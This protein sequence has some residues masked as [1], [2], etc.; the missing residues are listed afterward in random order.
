MLAVQA[1]ADN[2]QFGLDADVRSGL[3]S[4][5]LRLVAD[6]ELADDLTQEALAKAHEKADQFRGEGTRAAWL[7]G[8]ALNI[9]RDHFRKENRRVRVTSNPDL[10]NSIPDQG[11]IEAEYLENEMAVCIRRFVFALPRRQS[12]MIAMHDLAGLDH[13][14]AAKRLDISPANGRVLLHRGRKN[15]R[16]KLEKECKLDFDGDSAPCE[17][18]ARK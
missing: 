3:R 18:R 8:I 12:E 16:L 13:A 15:L 14:E 5:V 17:P 7:R 9:V 1:A 11:S 4:F 6:R 10:L 2:R